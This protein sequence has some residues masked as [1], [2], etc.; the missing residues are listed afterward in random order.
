[1]R[2]ILYYFLW[3][4]PYQLSKYLSSILQPLTNASRHKL[5]S[6]ENFINSIKTVKI[7][8][9]YR[10]VSFDV[11]PFFDKSSLKKSED[12]AFKNAL[13]KAINFL[14]DALRCWEWLFKHIQLHF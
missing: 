6:T 14:Q 2:P 13:S 7:P 5:Q 8:S 11:K 4:S 10:L 1:M 3:I 9:D 12:K